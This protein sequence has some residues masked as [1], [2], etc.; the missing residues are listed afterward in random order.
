METDA[1]T[2]KANPWETLTFDFANEA[3]GTAELNLTYNYNRLIIFFNFGVTGAAAGAQTFYFDDVLFVTGSSGPS[4]NT[5]TCSAPCID[6]ASASVKYEPFEP[7][8]CTPAVSTTRPM[9]PTR[10]RSS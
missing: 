9:R 7:G 10:W 1:V 4:G 6:F 2:T 3:T 8:V 5:G